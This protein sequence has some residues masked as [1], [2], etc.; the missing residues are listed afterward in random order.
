MRG[1]IYQP[2]PACALTT[3]ARVWHERTQLFIIHRTAADGRPAGAAALPA[4][5]AGSHKGR[6]AGTK[7][8]SSLP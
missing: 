6:W 2:R 4:W 7:L 3:D 5:G 1:A 8:Q